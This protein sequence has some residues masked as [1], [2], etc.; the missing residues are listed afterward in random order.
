MGATHIESFMDFFAV[1]KCFISAC[2]ELCR[3]HSF[4]DCFK[5]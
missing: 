4:V 1:S 2:T 5:S 3:H